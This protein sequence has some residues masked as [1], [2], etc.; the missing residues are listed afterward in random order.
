MFAGRRR[1]RH[2]V[3]SG[4]ELIG[5]DRGETRGG[6]MFANADTDADDDADDDVK[7]TFSGLKARFFPVYRTY[8]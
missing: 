5:G 3:R 8:N 4:R 7:L 6:M 1:V 2:H